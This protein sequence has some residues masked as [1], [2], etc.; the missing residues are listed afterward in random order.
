MSYEWPYGPWTVDY[1]DVCDI[2]KC[3]IRSEPTSWHE[4]GRVATVSMTSPS[5]VR[6]LSRAPELYDHLTDIVH[7]IDERVMVLGETK[8]GQYDRAAQGQWDASMR[9]A[10]KLIKELS[11]Q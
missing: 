3:T 7:M 10:R 9:Q 5:I 11:G 4:G 1:D 8:G 2:G 6:L